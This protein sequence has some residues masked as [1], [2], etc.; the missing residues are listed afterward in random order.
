MIHA[1]DD[2][3]TIYKKYFQKQTP[4]LKKGE[5]VLTEEEK[6]DHDI[7]LKKYIFKNNID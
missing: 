1:P 2:A 3:A 7:N 6:L 5:K 4:N